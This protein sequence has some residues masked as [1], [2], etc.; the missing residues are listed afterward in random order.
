PIYVLHAEAFTQLLDFFRLDKSD[1]YHVTARSNALRPSI[2]EIKA[3]ATQNTTPVSNYFEL[4]LIQDFTAYFKEI[5]PDV[6]RVELF[7]VM[8]LYPNNGQLQFGDGIL[9]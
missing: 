4:F 1:A 8:R 3:E 9:K 6:E 2:G 7:Q 5:Y